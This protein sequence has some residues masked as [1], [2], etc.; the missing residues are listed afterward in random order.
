[1][2]KK[3]FFVFIILLV[4]FAVVVQMQPKSFRVTRTAVVNAPAQ[5]VFNQVNDLH[6]WHEWS[7]WA[8]L[9]PQAKETFEGS[10]TGVGSTMRW[11]GNSDVGKGSMTI[12]ESRPNEFIKFQ[13]HFIEPFEGTHH[14]EF[15]FKEVAAGTEVSWSMYGENNFIGKAFSLIMDCDKMIGADFEKGLSQLKAVVEPR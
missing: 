4:G 1:M 5:T 14:A 8:K 15:T 13:L 10:P 11:E 7:P 3:I 9:D 2:I 12:V 6:A